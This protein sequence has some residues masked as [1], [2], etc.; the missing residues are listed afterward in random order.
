MEQGEYLFQDNTWFKSK[1]HGSDGFF[2]RKARK[3]FL[4]THDLAS[5]LNLFEFDYKALS[6]ELQHDGT[7]VLHCAK[8]TYLDPNEER[9]YRRGQA[10]ADD[11]KNSI[12]ILLD[13]M[14]TQWKPEYLRCPKLNLNQLHKS[15][16][17]T[18][19]LYVQRGIR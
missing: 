10:W 9:E 4:F 19:L 2:W 6:D 15:L 7:R 5:A 14:V 1:I 11:A 17:P 3:M 12:R 16:I 13:R 18:P 8:K